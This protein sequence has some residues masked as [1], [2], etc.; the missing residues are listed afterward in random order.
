MKTFKLLRAVI[1]EHMHVPVVSIDKQFVDVNDIETK[2]EINKNLALTVRRG[3]TSPAEAIVKISKILA[4]Y[5]IQVPKIDTSEGSFDRKVV[6]VYQYDYW[7]GETKDG[8]FLAPSEF[9]KEQ[10]FL[11]F[12]SMLMNGIFKCTAEVVDKKGLDVTY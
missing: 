3:F 8:T 6:P 10:N 7:T 12:T 11:V 5:G 9:P 2:N 1:N 4:M